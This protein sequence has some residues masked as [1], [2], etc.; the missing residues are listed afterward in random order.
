MDIL[1]PAQRIFTSEH[2]VT[3]TLD[4]EFLGVADGVLSVSFIAPASMV[5][6]TQ[7]GL[8]HSGLTTLILDTVMGGVVMGEMDPVQPI[9]TTGLTVQHLRRPLAGEKL[10][11][12]A[13]VEGM[14]ADVAHVTGRLVTE[15][16][17][18][19]LAAA[20]GSFMMGTRSKPLGVRV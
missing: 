4:V 2:P 7:S 10:L 20:T 5:S 15:D 18:E 12:R 9:A 1:H 3:K 19:L 13:K 6:D 16:D 14:H 17:G 11:C 8:V